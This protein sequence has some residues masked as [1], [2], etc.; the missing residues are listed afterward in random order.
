MLPVKTVQPDYR[1]SNF[2]DWQFYIM[3]ERI[4]AS[5]KVCDIKKTESISKRIKFTA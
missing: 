3:C 4:K 1:F 2:T 5:F